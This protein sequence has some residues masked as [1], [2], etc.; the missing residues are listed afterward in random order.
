MS[1]PNRYVVVSVLINPTCLVRCKL[2]LQEVFA[3]VSKRQK[4]AREK[5]EALRF[6]QALPF[7]TPE[8]KTKNLTAYSQAQG[9]TGKKPKGSLLGD[10]QA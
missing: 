2:T 6:S 5:S 10:V 7:A 1:K 9:L 3:M 8:E 4:T